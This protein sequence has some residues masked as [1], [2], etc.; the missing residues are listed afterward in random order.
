LAA[1]GKRAPFLC[2]GKQKAAAKITEFQEGFLTSLGMTNKNEMRELSF[3]KI[4]DPDGFGIGEFA[5]AVGAEFTA[6]AG[7]FYTAER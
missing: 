7:C 1:S 2:Q 4:A 5:N 6:V 3:C